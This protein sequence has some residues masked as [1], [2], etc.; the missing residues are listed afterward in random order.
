MSAESPLMTAA[1][2]PTT[3]DHDRRFLVGISRA[4]GGAVFFSL[5]L[6]MTME[7]WLLGFAMDRLRLA[8]FMTLMIPLLIAL[9]HYAGFE[10]TVRWSEDVLDGFVG[11]GVGIL[12]SAVILLLLNV[13]DFTQPASEIVGKVCLQA[14]PAA[15]G[16][17][18]ASS[19]LA[20]DS[21]E[22]E[23]GEE[24]R[25][26]AG[27]PAQIFFMAVGAVFM[28]FN[29]A[30]T[31]EIVA[32][33]GMITPWHAIVIIGVSLLM[34]H[35]FVYAVSF[36][37]TPAI[38]RDAGG[39]RL[40]ACFTLVGY[41]AALIVSAYVLWT[42]GRFDGLGPNAALLQTIVLAFPASLGA[43]GARLIL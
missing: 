16:A 43:A 17:I 19:Q 40:F 24:R 13:I 38:D 27:Y 5:P 22:E 14:V 28:S 15:F 39:V 10:E 41:A 30:P 32:I 26:E 31:E 25:R 4:F 9:D 36:R 12:S 20:H 34:M 42:F 18:L 35:A 11:Y 3:Q 29:I 6:M 8:G 21:P 33:A 1:P 37:G 7:M 23:E 2:Q